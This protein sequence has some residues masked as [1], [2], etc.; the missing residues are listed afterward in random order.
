[1]AGHLAAMSEF[2]LRGYNVAIPMVDVGDDVFVVDDRDGALRRVQVKSAEQAADAS[3]GEGGKTVV[4]RLSRRQIRKAK[5]NELYY[6]LM[7]RWGG[8]W[9]FLLVPRVD[10]DELHKAHVFRS[11]DAAGRGTKPKG[12]ED[13]STDALMLRIQWSAD[14]ATGW[15]ASFARYLDRWP[16]DFP[17][18]TDGSGSI[19]QDPVP[20]RDPGTGPGPGGSPAP[21]T[22]P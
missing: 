4:Y 7:I 13:V 1:M 19:L 17:E 6:M 12:D 11:A 14:D 10:L 8:R 2:V 21:P 16:D 18:I 15:G 22:G 3:D 20:T 9:R 5:R